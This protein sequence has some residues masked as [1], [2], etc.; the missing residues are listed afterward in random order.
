MKMKKVTVAVTQMVSRKESAKSIAAADAL[1]RQAAQAGAN[2]VLI[3][4]LFETDYF[5]QKMIDQNILLATTLEENPAVAHFKKLA[6]E[7][8]V[9]IPVSFFEKAGQARYNT[10]AIIDADGSLLGTYR[11]SHIPDGAGYSEKFYFNVGD[12]GF[13]V[14]ETKYAKIGLG[15]CWDQW[16]PEAARCMA[17][18]GAEILL[19]PTAIGSEP[20]DGGLDSMLHWRTAMQG[21][22]AANI[23]PVL[24]SNRIGVET[25]QDYKITFYGS[26]FI[27]DQY[28]QIVRQMDRISEGFSCAEFDL[29]EIALARR[30][31]GIFRDRRPDLYLPLLTL[32]GSTPY[33]KK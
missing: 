12:S 1:V 18:L 27:A 9:V 28:G 30:A 21:H 6:A 8:D 29:D 22:A 17:L 3:Q 32:D 7:L 26:S 19:Y 20:D 15:V 24:A 11:K 2:I 14:W 33:I 13:K 4:E 16:F 5:C 25:C 10:L 23:M 31:W